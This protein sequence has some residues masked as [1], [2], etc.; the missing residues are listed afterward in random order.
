MFE[1]LT[2]GWQLI[3]G[4]LVIAVV[5]YLLGSVNFAI[6]TTRAK[7]HEDIRDYGSGNAGMT[8]VLRTQ[9]KKNATVVFIGDFLKGAAAVGFGY[10]IG[11]LLFG[12]E[13]LLFGGYIGF[14]SVVLGHMFPVFYQFKGGKGISTSAGAALV[15]EPMMFLAILLTFLA[16]TLISRIVS[17]GS[18]CAAVMLPLSMFLIRFFQNGKD[19]LFETLFCCVIAALVIFMHRQNISRLIHGTENRFGKKKDKKDPS[20]E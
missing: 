2:F 15:I 9:G 5:G 3:V 13:S 19:I 18:I 17:L 20:E 12:A 1:H 11:W 14:L 10:L 7:L 8:N 16:V 6:I 4:I